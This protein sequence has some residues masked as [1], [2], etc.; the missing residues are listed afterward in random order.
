MY[1]SIILF[2]LV[3]LYASTQST[4]SDQLTDSNAWILF[5]IAAATVIYYVLLR[6]RG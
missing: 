5:S 6:V 4:I 3:M 1:L 2:I